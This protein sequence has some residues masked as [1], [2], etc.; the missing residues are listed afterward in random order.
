MYTDTTPLIISRESVRNQSNNAL[1]C[2]WL[3]RGAE[4]AGTK[5]SQRTQQR[6]IVTDI[7]PIFDNLGMRTEAHRP[8]LRKACL[9]RSAGGAAVYR[10]ARI[11]GKTRLCE[12]WWH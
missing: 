9:E 7:N 8:R 2:G 11:A 3:S 1:F 12:A 5:E 6:V 4:Q 10:P